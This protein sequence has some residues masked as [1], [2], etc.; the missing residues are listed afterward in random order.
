MIDIGDT[1][2]IPSVD[3]DFGGDDLDPVRD[4]ILAKDILGGERV[5]TVEHYQEKLNALIP[6]EV[7]LSTVIGL[8]PHH[9]AAGFPS[10]VFLFLRTKN[11][12]C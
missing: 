10:F 12:P 4:S 9:W 8:S 6:N 2:D 1:N 3:V 5:D 7:D 11:I